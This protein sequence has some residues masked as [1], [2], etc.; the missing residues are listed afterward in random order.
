MSAG[1]SIGA[2]SNNNNRSNKAKAAAAAVAAALP[3]AFVPPTAFD[4]NTHNDDDSGFDV[5]DEFGDAAAPAGPRRRTP[6]PPSLLSVPEIPH[7]TL[8]QYRVIAGSPIFTHA[9]NGDATKLLDAID[10]AR[11]AAAD[12]DE[13]A[14]DVNAA[15]ADGTTALLI[16]VE[17]RHLGCVEALLLGN[18]DVNVKRRHDGCTPLLA[19]A[20]QG[21][22]GIVSK[23]LSAKADV[24]AH[25]TT[26]LGLTA[27]Y[28]AC[29]RGNHRALRLLLDAKVSRN[30][31]IGSQAGRCGW[32]PYALAAMAFALGTWCTCLL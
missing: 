26:P 16:A 24:A 13:N 22:A 11:D 18:A 8:E 5:E 1:A 3:R 7:N 10:D 21:N 32:G 23:L 6:P 2:G 30:A 9:A 17:E 20:L 29:F 14:P 28:Q 12:G 4:D 19:A 25:L 15:L 27:V 31:F